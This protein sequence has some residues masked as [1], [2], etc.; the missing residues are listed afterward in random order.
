MLV[1]YS[2]LCWILY[3]VYVHHHVGPT[4]GF[5]GISFDSKNH[6]SCI[7]FSSCVFLAG[8]KYLY[9]C[10]EDL[11]FMNMSYMFATLLETLIAQLLDIMG[12]CT[13]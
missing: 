9:H 10:F 7:G 2:F 12:N 5:D 13:I 1:T 4:H 11:N 8:N 6:G 3:Y